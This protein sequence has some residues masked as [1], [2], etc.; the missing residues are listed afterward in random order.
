MHINPEQTNL[1][2][3]LDQIDRTAENNEHVT[4]RAVIE[5]L[6]HRSFGPLLLMAGLVIL[7]PLIGDIPGIPAPCNYLVDA[8]QHR[9]FKVPGIGLRIPVQTDDAA[10]LKFDHR[11]SIGGAG[12]QI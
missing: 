6:G 1:E 11:R 5:A 12:N 9:P 8:G 4:Q 2:Q 10:I 3:L 7:A